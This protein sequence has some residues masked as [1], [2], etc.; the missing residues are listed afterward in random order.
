MNF[1]LLVAM[2]SAAVITSDLCEM[3]YSKEKIAV[4]NECFNCIISTVCGLDR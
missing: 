4:F 2:I 1:V 3:R